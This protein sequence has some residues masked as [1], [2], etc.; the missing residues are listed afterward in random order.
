MHLHC[1]RPKSLSPLLRH[2]EGTENQFISGHCVSQNERACWESKQ[3]HAQV[4]TITHT[5]TQSL[6]SIS[7][8]SSNWLKFKLVLTN[9]EIQEHKHFGLYTQAS[10]TDKQAVDWL[11][12]HIKMHTY[13]HT[14]IHMC[15]STG[16]A[17]LNGGWCCSSP[18]YIDMC[19]IHRTD[20][21]TCVF[22]LR[23]YTYKNTHNINIPRLSDT[24]TRR[25]ATRKYAWAIDCQTRQHACL[26]VAHWLWMGHL[27]MQMCSF[28]LFPP[29]AP[30]TTPSLILHNNPAFVFFNALLVF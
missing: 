10:N 13:I 1:V 11:L 8:L 3:V 30:R 12:W 14:Q 24:N 25:H 19:K 26:C 22:P 5:N 27:I 15:T 23:L 2:E 20:T 28:S 7:F 16:R 6:P 9:I 17:P 21:N 29:L 4:H 18:N